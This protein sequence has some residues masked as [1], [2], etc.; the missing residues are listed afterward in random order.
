MK[1][2]TQSY[3]RATEAKC[4]AKQVYLCSIRLRNKIKKEE[5][6]LLIKKEIPLS[7]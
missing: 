2:M 3:S 1:S 6:P 5:R 4:F 7:V